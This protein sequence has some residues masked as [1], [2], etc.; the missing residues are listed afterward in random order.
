M[1]ATEKK[2]IDFISRMQQLPGA[3]LSVFELVHV[4]DG[5]NGTPVE[6]FGSA[7]PYPDPGLLAQNILRA[8]GEHCEAF[9]MP[10]RYAIL[11]YRDGG[12]GFSAQMA[13]L[14]RP[15][16]NTSNSMGGVSE[17]PT[18]RGIISQMMRHTEAAYGSMVQLAQTVATMHE[19]RGNTAERYFNSF[20]AERERWTGFQA[21]RE[22][23]A[24]HAPGSRAGGGA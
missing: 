23:R 8:A 7:P 9:S 3:P 15:P 21:D 5:E 24:A 19:A 6:P 17:P 12:K 11:A 2:L 13:L 10:Q 16:T 18:D 1:D 4:T 22:D 20:M 14:L